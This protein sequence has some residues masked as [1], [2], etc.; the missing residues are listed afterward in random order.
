MKITAARADAFA[1]A[2]DPAVRAVLVYGPDAGLVRERADMLAR[3]VVEDVTDPFLVSELAGE[4]VAADPA[5]LS[6]EA[7]ALALTG[8]R[9]LVRVRDCGDGLARAVTAMLEGPAGDSLVVMLAG[10]L[11]PRSALRK[12]FESAKDAAALPCYADEGRDLDRLIHEV[13][14]D[15]S[16]TVSPEAVSYLTAN[17]GSDRAV[18]RSE[19]TKLALYAQGSGS[20]DLDDA[21]AV[22]GDSAALTLDDLVYAVG[23]GEMTAI[24]RTLQR[25]LQEG[26]APV[27]ILRALGRHLM[28]LQFAA[29]RVAAGEAPDRAVKALRPPVFFKR[30]AQFGRQL[31]Q[32]RG[33]RIA[34]AL[35][36]VLAAERG[37]KTTGMPDEAICGRALMQTAALANRG[38]RG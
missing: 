12:L 2:P 22:V 20:V 31:S 30:Q 14:G 16:V 28:R 38:R 35:D 34:R 26:Q 6:D 24:D 18:S 36:I 8:G 32:W 10:D 9:R 25:S 37:C 27:A 11:G 3:A 33:E 13:L 15:A 1:R 7:A 5:R 29:A 4:T 19:L 23:D 21:I 17:L